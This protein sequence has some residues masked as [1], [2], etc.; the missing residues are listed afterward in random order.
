MDTLE[1]KLVY[2]FDLMKF[3]SRASPHYIREKMLEDNIPSMVANY[4]YRVNSSF[5]LTS[6]VIENDDGEMVKGD[7]YQ[8]KLLKSGLPQGLP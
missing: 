3:F 5:P 6:G 2:E 7:V 4:V 1:E 8:S